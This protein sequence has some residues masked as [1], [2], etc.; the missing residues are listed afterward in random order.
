[1][2]VIFTFVTS[3]LKRIR[4]CDVRGP[5]KPLPGAF[6][7]AMDSYMDREVCLFNWRWRGRVV[8]TFVGSAVPYV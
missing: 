7:V 5:N 8:V 1:M 2:H 6:R 4:Q 3:F